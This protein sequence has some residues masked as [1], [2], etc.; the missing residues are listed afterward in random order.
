MSRRKF[1]IIGS[2]HIISLLKIYGAYND[3]DAVYKNVWNQNKSVVVQNL[4]I[5][6][7][8]WDGYGILYNTMIAADAPILREGTLY[9]QPELTEV[10]KNIPE[11]SEIIFS[12]LRGQEYAISALVDNPSHA[13]FIGGDGSFEEGR[14]WMSRDDAKIWVGGIAESIL[15]T[16]LALKLQ[17]PNAKIIHFQAPP[18]IEDE[19]YIYKNPEG[20]GELFKKYGVK[21]FSMRL[22]IYNLMYQELEKKLEKYGI[23]NIPAPSI[24]LTPSGGMK[25]DFASGCLHGN[26]QYA[27]GLVLQ[28]QQVLNHVSSI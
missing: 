19:E 15:T 2:S 13:D 3:D 24:A 17:F 26:E 5:S 9:I 14:Q 28:I 8:K 22:N 25:A 18:P 7:K 23:V 10:F 16:N 21:P 27:K 1:S 11:D 6:P 4:P 20:F 12:L